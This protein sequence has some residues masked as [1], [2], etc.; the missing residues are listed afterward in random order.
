MSR[1]PNNSMLPDDENQNQTGNQ[2]QNPGQYPNQYSIHGNSWDPSLSNTAPNEPVQG[3]NGQNAG[4]NP[5]GQQPPMP[6][7]QH[8]NQPNPSQ[9]EDLNCETRDIPKISHGIL[10]E[11]FKRPAPNPQAQAQACDSALCRLRHLLQ[12]YTDNVA[13][14]PSDNDS[15]LDVPNLFPIEDPGSTDL[16][17]NNTGN[18][19]Y[20]PAEPAPVESQHEPHSTAVHHNVV[21]T[22][23]ALPSAPTFQ[24]SFGGPSPKKRGR[25]ASP[26][27]TVPAPKRMRNL[28]PSTSSD[29]GDNAN[30]S[31]IP[32]PAPNTTSPSSR[33]LQR[34]RKR[35]ADIDEEE[36]DGENDLVSDP[37]PQKKPRGEPAASKT[38]SNYLKD[39]KK[40][41]HEKVVAGT[42]CIFCRENPQS[43]ECNW[44]QVRQSN[45][46]EVY[47]LE[48]TNCADH[49][50]KNKDNPELAGHKCLVQGPKTLIHFEHKRYGV[51]DPQGYEKTACDACARKKQG[52]ICDVDTILG[53]Y[54]LNCRRQGECKVDL[55]ETMPLRRPKKLT[56]RPWYRHPCDRCFLR[57]KNGDVKGDDCCSWI[58]DRGEWEE[59]RACKQCQRDGTICL[60]LG[61][62]MD[63]F[64]FNAKNIPQ[65]WKIR[66]EFE[67]DKENTKGDKEK[68][69][70]YAE[71]LPNTTWRKPCQGCKTAG[72][73]TDCL[74]MWHQPYNACERC[75][76][77]GIDCMVEEEK[78][79]FRQHPIFDLSRVGFGQFTPFNACTQCVRHGL[80]CDR[81]RPCDSCRHRK[82]KCDAFNW[83]KF[84]CIDRR[85]LTNR[86][87]KETYSPGPLYYLALG[88]GAGGVNDL[89]DGQKL[90]HWIGPAA[91]MYGLTDA[92]GGPEQYRFVAASHQHHRPPEGIA[93]PPIPSGDKQLK[94]TSASELRWLVA[95][96]WLNQQPQVPKNDLQG[97]QKV[98]DLLRDH[99]NLQMKT[100]GMEHNLPPP[101]SGVRC[102]Q[103]GPVLS[104]IW[105][106][107]DPMLPSAL[108]NANDTQSQGFSP[109]LTYQPSNQYGNG[110][111]P[112]QNVSA[113]QT[114][115]HQPSAAQ[116]PLDFTYY[117]NESGQDPAAFGQD[118]GFDQQQLHTLTRNSQ[119]ADQ[120]MH[121]GPDQEPFDYTHGELQMAQGHVP[122]TPQGWGNL[123]QEQLD[124][125]SQTGL[126]QDQTGDQQ[127]SQSGDT[128]NWYEKLAPLVRGTADDES[129]ERP[130]YANSAI[131]AKDTE[132]DQ[133][134]PHSGP[135]APDQSPEGSNESQDEFSSLVDWE[136][137]QTHRRSQASRG[138]RWLKPQTSRGSKKSSQERTAGGSLV[139]KKAN[140][141]DA[142]NPFLG[143]TFG[144]DQKPRFTE[145]PKGSRWKVFNHLEG[146]DMSEWHESKSKEPEEESQ[147]RLFSIVNGQTNQPTPV[148]NVLGDVPREDKV[149]RTKRYCAEPGEGGWG[150]CA[151]WNTDGHG[152]ATCQSSA[153][154]NTA[155]PYFPV[156]N[157]CTRG[158]VKY[159][160]Q[161]E[162][163]P[164]TESELLSMRAYLCNECAGQ[165]SAGA[166]NAVQNQ[167]VGTRR[168]Y[169]I[170]ADEAQSQNRRKLVNGLSKAANLKKSTEALTGCSCANR[171]LGTSLCRFHRL[172]YAEEVMKQAALMQEWR[173]SRFKKAVCPSCLAQKPSEQVNVSA[174]VDGF[175]TGAPTAWACVV[176]ND[177]VV[178]EQ[179]DVNNQPKVIDK[180]LWNLNI[181]RKLLGPHREIATGRVLG[182]VV[183][184]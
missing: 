27:T 93:L 79:R 139:P 108:G 38:K 145:K 8:A 14:I 45:G 54:C 126:P 131:L 182:E 63:G 23:L 144:P 112:Q 88:Y 175:V 81:Q 181:G 173:L 158:N 92:K 133:Q 33:Q 162:H 125:H 176:C 53:Y 142:F 140:G 177:W 179:N 105:G 113:P 43:K 155:L 167:I 86:Q 18:V 15:S 164:I 171:M 110:Y 169:G 12:R 35:K 41:D 11:I 141:R 89:K 136:G 36:H 183:S 51:G 56:R 128:E 118:G 34:T 50:S 124:F 83:K 5:G 99:Q 102:F 31:E 121:G 16:D 32:G 130:P 150:S 84:G 87:N 61:E 151:A 129:G 152:Q 134:E 170:A 7:V 72:K 94:D 47:D 48:C 17:P 119:L 40:E 67:A 156:C 165:M 91:P 78:G 117:R 161:H 138:E 147:V 70:E 66:P 163:N 104:D 116:Q 98:W 13:M 69:H 6:Q 46:P 2:G 42:I 115:L 120:P 90:E 153:H 75:T 4:L 96:F 44:E 160:F 122:P 127:N 123:N 143:F 146:I 109:S 159:L 55:S 174:N 172:Y 19:D 39:L 26:D 132:N 103:G 62:L 3:S 52:G 95:R 135:Q 166:P 85:K 28:Q 1:N 30:S 64:S 77:L 114:Q 82:A 74:V 168:V 178:N 65:S 22:P 106:T 37:R 10:D 97:Y 154:R 57:H 76:Q 100:A 184:V 73:I 149:I 60:D 68:W 111:N 148:R 157:D 29:E 137:G 59:R 58:R 71:V 25:A 80:N 21:N 24:A 20:T 180:P 9:P 107:Q 101:I 49:R